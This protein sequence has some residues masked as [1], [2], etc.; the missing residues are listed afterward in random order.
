MRE[1]G[2]RGFVAGLV[3][4]AFGF[5]GWWRC[6]WVLEGEGSVGGG[7]VVVRRCRRFVPRLRMRDVGHPVRWWCRPLQVAARDF[8]R[9]S[10]SGDSHGVL[11]FF[12][13]LVGALGGAVLA[14]GEHIFDDAG[15]AFEVGAVLADG[16]DG[17]RR[18]RR[19]PSSCIRCSRCWRSDSLRRLLPARSRSRRLCGGRRRGRRRGCRGRRGGCARGR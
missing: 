19:L 1:G 18:W 12:E 9:R 7:G 10:C 4:L 3:A 5:G 17:L 14:V 13:G 6:G 2:L 8:F 16:G 15:A 11:G